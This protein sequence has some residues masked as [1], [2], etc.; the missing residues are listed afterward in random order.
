MYR[1]GGGENL[2]AFHLDRLVDGATYFVRVDATDPS[3]VTLHKTKAD[4][5][6]GILSVSL[7]VPEDSGFEHR[8][9]PVELPTRA[10]RGVAVQALSTESTFTLAAS[11]AVGFGGLT[12]NLVV[13]FVDSDTAAFIGADAAINTGNDGMEGADQSVNVTAVNRA[14]V[15][16]AALN[17][18]IGLVSLAGSVDLGMIRNDTSASLGIGSEVR[19]RGDVE[20][21]ALSGT[22]VD[23]FV[24]GLGLSVAGFGLSAS[25]A[26]HSIGAALD[27]D[28][29]GV[30]GTISGTGESVHGFVDAQIALLTDTASGGVAGLLSQYASLVGGDHPAAGLLE[31]AAPSGAV[32]DAVN[33]TQSGEGTSAVINGAVVSAGGDVRVAAVEKLDAAVDTSFTLAF[34]IPGT[35]AFT[36][37]I[38][39]ASV[40]SGGNALAQIRNA[41][42]ISAGGDVDVRARGTSVRNAV[43][44]V[45][46]NFASDTIEASIEG[47]SLT[48]T[49]DLAVSADSNSVASY[50]S[51][52]P[53]LNPLRLRIALNDVQDTIDAHI[54]GSVIDATGAVRID[55]TD[56]A[57]IEALVVAVTFI[58][59]GGVAVGL[60]EAGNTIRNTVTAY[61]EGGSV[62]SET[63]GVDVIADANHTISATA[64]G[65]SGTAA[66]AV[67]GS[68]TANSISNIVDA[69]ISQ[70][71]DVDAHG[72]I[73]V[74]ATE[75]SQISVF[76]GGFAGSGSVGVGA[77]ASADFI[78]CQVRAYI[79]RSSATSAVGDVKVLAVATPTV[80][81][82]T[83]G[84]AGAGTFAAGGSVAGTIV[85]GTVDA[86]IANDASVN[87]AGDILVKATSTF[88]LTTDAGAA[89][90]GLGAAG[91]GGSLITARLSTVTTAFVSSG[92]TLSAGDD[93][94]VIA[95]TDITRFN[96]V[97]FAGGG[98]L[99]GIQAA[100]IDLRS[101][102][103]SR[104]FMD[105][106][107]GVE[108]AD[109]VTVRA[110]TVS[111]MDANSV[112]I[113]GGAV[114]V[115][116]VFTNAREA[117][118]TWAA[119]AA[120]VTANA[121]TVEA[122]STTTID[123]DGTVAN[124]GIGAFSGNF[125][126]AEADGTVHASIDAGAIQVVNDVKLSAES[127]ATADADLF[128]LSLGGLAVGFN[129]ATA[130]V[131]PDVDAI[132][133]G[134]A[135]I[136]AGGAIT[137]Q[138]SHAKTG[139]FGA[140]AEANASGGGLIGGNG[141]LSNATAGAVVDTT[142]E[143]G[144]RLDAG[145]N[146]TIKAS[147]E[148]D[149]K[150]NALG[151]TGGVVG[152]GINTAN[153]D[154][155]GSTATS[156]NGAVVAEGNVTI[157]SESTNVIEADATGGS[158]GVVAISAASANVL[159]QDH[160]TVTTIGELASLAAGDVLLVE[161]RMSTDADAN[162]EVD[163]FGAG[164]FAT[165]HATTEVTGAATTTTISNG[166]DLRG[167]TVR[168]L[169]RVTNLDAD[170]TADSRAGAAGADS[171]ATATVN[172]DSDVSI[173][174]RD[175][176]RVLGETRVEIKAGHESL[177][178]KARA[179]AE[180]SGLGGDSDPAAS[181]VLDTLTT[182]T[183]ASGAEITTRDLFVEA[184]AQSNPGYEAEAIKRGAVIDTGESSGSRSVTHVRRIDFNATVVLLGPLSPELVVDEDGNIVKLINIDTPAITADEIVL[185]DIVNPGGIFAGTITFSITPSFLD[186]DP[187]GVGTVTSS[188][189]ITG[190]PEFEFRTAF[191]RV[192]IENASS[193]DLRVGNIDVLNASAQFGAN[194]S[195]NVSNKSGFSFTTTTNP[196]S[197]VVTIESAA[198]VFL[199]GFIHN[200]LGTTELRSLAGD[201]VSAAAAVTAIR[202]NTIALD[203]ANGTI[204]AND[205]RLR[206]DSNRL[207]AKAGGDVL[208]D[209]ASGDLTW[210]RSLPML[211]WSTC[212]PPGR[213]WMATP[214]KRRTSS[215]P[216]S[217]CSRKPAESA[218]APIRSIST[219]PTKRPR[220]CSR[221]RMA[222]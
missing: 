112:G 33:D 12:G 53:G 217:C 62:A 143:S 124:G 192:T 19:A 127:K 130:T 200:P 80:D 169:A 185:G 133:G 210:S 93:I 121:L 64:V 164:V 172:T 208:I 11:G 3:L 168:I 31:D 6:T 222:T 134:A 117:N 85:G 54:S 197:S 52:L 160:S 96:A 74:S 18:N 123:T 150:A 120:D 46:L 179:V 158:G 147:G 22:E 79:D 203:A 209:E 159:V 153:A 181:N 122:L 132:I 221:P 212:A 162:S 171:D 29:L 40:L 128:G 67:A 30:L 91:F 101:E 41:A 137:V 23:S 114:A 149:A 118:T 98:G 216:A 50:S 49:G 48:T 135:G 17:L 102:T 205:G 57:D 38:N 28:S 60:A 44:T 174:I 189:T 16:D 83:I 140:R 42:D 21:Y 87:A 188:A 214:P 61:I 7:D 45:V 103:E 183:T 51:K 71:A 81:T 113:S 186:S 47:S 75:I 207:T 219:P 92:V 129:R 218:P 35:G 211:G 161:A 154:G 37:D 199:D 13:V 73:G 95:K 39:L 15:F 2:G 72:T 180:T 69:H 77:G 10:M 142:I 163:A 220:P 151:I 1:N 43:G 106:D 55:A 175:Q 94:E 145:G 177:P 125:T 104:A 109:S 131:T 70:G 59:A 68:V 82:L 110:E 76:A 196:G 166:A 4:A 206:I 88:D 156:M 141:A 187:T 5:D 165:T 63:A 97:T 24:G 198:D 176:A 90:I 148:N 184:H 86:H 173:T 107:P 32:T 65:G 202:S 8:L 157:L 182:V 138:A 58:G 56:T 27:D 20:V 78:A 155:M 152:V 36:F 194:I 89:A 25:A 178:T 193:R 170:A 201:I 190:A 144:A 108:M 167:D 14:K 105:S 126:A 195:V 84:G 9:E 34:G 116:A 139:S 191:D 119:L 99:V 215:P 26:I 213:S 111:N 146:V 66:A 204:G 100:F 136:E 115:G